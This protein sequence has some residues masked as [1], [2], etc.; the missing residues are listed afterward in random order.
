VHASSLSVF[1][2]KTHVVRHS[3]LKHSFCYAQE[4]NGQLV[5]EG[6]N[7]KEKVRLAS[8]SKLLTTYWSVG[9]LGLDYR[10]KTKFQYNPRTKDLHI[11]GSRDPFFGRRSFFYIMSEL[12]RLGITEI[13][14]LT[15][16]QAVT[17]FPAVEEK[18]THHTSIGV[19]G[20]L[21]V[22]SVKNNLANIMN[23]SSWDKA[24]HDRYNKFKEEAKDEDLSVSSK[25][26]MSVQAVE[27]V[28]SETYQSES[29]SVVYQF[30]SAPLYSYLKEMNKYSLNYTADELYK[31]LGGRNAFKKYVEQDLGLGAQD[32]EIYTGSGLPDEINNERFDN[33][34]SCESV[35]RVIQ[36]IS[37]KL[38]NYNSESRNQF[39]LKDIM[40]V[41][42]VD[43]GTIGGSYQAPGVRGSMVAKTGT[44]NQAITLAGALSTKEGKV[45]F[46]V[47]WQIPGPGDRFA[48][49]AARDSVV[50]TLIRDFGGGVPLSY[51]PKT[52][53]PFDYHSSLKENESSQMGMFSFNRIFTEAE[54]AIDLDLNGLNEN[55]P[56]DY[57][58][59]DIPDVDELGLL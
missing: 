53:T 37:Q 59:N 10:F 39:Q 50:L 38:K 22:G 21:T 54:P 11:T 44:I 7:A 48:A 6:R 26:K 30:M 45:Y 16:D 20:G 46:G 1:D 13:N 28:R 15:F 5:F 27:Y 12:N 14:K 25:L 23:T 4:S 58:S 52:F 17:F 49:R 43:D 31:V 47:F 24:Q 2:Q 55:T 57:K 35:V 19:T 34:A 40:L 51:S 33:E 42:G 29:G 32:L 56:K 18:S 9:V 41:A 3:D 8:V 36:S